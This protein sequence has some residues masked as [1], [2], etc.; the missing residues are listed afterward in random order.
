VRSSSQQCSLRLEAA[1][2]VQ[3]CPEFVRL[4]EPFLEIAGGP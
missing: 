3:H 1:K 2:E 4:V